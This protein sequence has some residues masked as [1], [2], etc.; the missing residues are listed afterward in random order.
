MQFKKTP[1]VAHGAFLLSDFCEYKK[2]PVSNGDFFISV[3]ND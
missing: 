3:F 1:D 2:I